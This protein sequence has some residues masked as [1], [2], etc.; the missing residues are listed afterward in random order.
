MRRAVST[1]SLLGLL[2]VSAG[3]PA[4]A[5]EPSK[6]EK[7]PEAVEQSLVA[8]AQGLKTDDG[9]TVMDT[10][11]YA[12]RM[13]PERFKLAGPF[14]FEYSDDGELDEVNVC[15]FTGMKRLPD[16]TYCSLT[17][18]VSKDHK[19]LVPLPERTHENLMRYS[20]MYALM[21]GRD[22][23]L[24]EIDDIYDQYCIDSKT[25]AKLC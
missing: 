1:L 7:L 18:E 24:R 20:T 17:W 15:F 3:G 11:R 8:Q 25:G 14:E 19:S 21:G 16:D 2:S 10:L 6:V 4:L 9:S 23:F 12:E 5:D 13:R 22:T